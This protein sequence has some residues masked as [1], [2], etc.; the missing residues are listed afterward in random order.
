MQTQSFDEGKS[1]LSQPDGPLQHPEESYNLRDSSIGLSDTIQNAIPL[2][3]QVQNIGFF[4][5][6]ADRQEKS[7]LSHQPVV[8]NGSQRVAHF[9]L[10][11]AKARNRTN[12]SH[13]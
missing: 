13:D 2:S 4:D 1:H 12:S 3:E 7:F 6:I 8:A 11:S 9:E 5:K 10:E